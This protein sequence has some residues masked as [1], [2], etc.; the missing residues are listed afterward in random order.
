MASL[1]EVFDGGKAISALKVDIYYN[2]LTTYHIEDIEMA[3]KKMIIGRVYPSFPKPAEII[4]EIQ[5]TTE[6]QATTAWIETIMAIRRIGA[7]ESVQFEDPIIHSVLQFLG[8]WPDAGNWLDA[9]LKWKQKEFERL[10]SIM[11]KSDRHP[12]YLPG[13]HEGQNGIEQTKIVKIGHEPELKM[14]AGGRP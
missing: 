4:Q 1:A 2:A 8:G 6:D 11:A 9:E 12:R 7:Y 13:I 14:I 3:V 5:G 10:Y